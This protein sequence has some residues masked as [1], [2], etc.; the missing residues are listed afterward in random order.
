[1]RCKKFEPMAS[2]YLDQELTSIEL[3]EYRA[4][5]G[6]CT[7]CSRYLQELEET[8]L[9]FKNVRRPEVPRE[10]HSYVM[11]AIERRASGEVSLRQEAMEWVLTLNPRPLSFATGAVFSIMLFAITL[12]GF[13][14]LPV[15]SANSGGQLTQASWK[16]PPEPVLSSLEEY[17][18]YNDISMKSDM[19]SHDASATSSVDGYELPRMD[20]STGSISSFVYLAFPNPGPESMVA[21][22][23]VDRNGRGKLVDM[24]D[25][26]KDPMAVEQLWWTLQDFDPVFRP[27]ILDGQPV[28][29]RIIF[30]AVKVDVWG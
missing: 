19:P 8:S 12:A 6:V 20:N 29:T 5:L 23:E 21:M 25:D 15:N 26:P 1:M 27:A 16:K 7:P 13:K 30:F 2:A 14:P 9:F 11:T 3:Q 10:L 24:I 22:V 17:G 18:R 4:H 28:A